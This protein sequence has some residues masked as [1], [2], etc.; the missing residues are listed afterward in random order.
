MHVR[1]GLHL[2]GKG[3]IVFSENQLRSIDSGTVCKEL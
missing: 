1:D 3:A 2:K